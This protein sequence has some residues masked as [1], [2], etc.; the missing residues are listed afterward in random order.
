MIVLIRCNDVV[1][2]TRAAKYI[3]YLDETNQRFYIIGWDRTATVAD[4]KNGTYFKRQAGVNVGGFKAAINRVFWMN[5]VIRALRKLNCDDIV[6]HACD[7][8]SAFP[9]AIYK[10]LF[11]KKAK[12]IFDVFDW[13]SAS[14]NDQGSVITAAFKYMENYTVKRSD[15]IIICEKERMDQIQVPFVSEKLYVL[16]NIPFFDD[17]SFVVKDEAFSFDNDKITFAYVGGFTPTR[18]LDEII[19]LA[20]DGLIN[21][22]IA[23]YGNRDIENRLSMRKCANIKY[24]G[25]VKYAF[26]LNIMY[27]ADIIYAMY[28]KVIPNHIYAAPNK[29]Y[30]ALFLGK[31]LFTTDGTIVE[32]KV[33]EFDTGFT[34]RENLTEIESVIR[35]IKTDEI[36]SKGKTAERVWEE[37]YQSYTLEFMKNEYQMMLTNG[38]N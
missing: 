24:F 23:G 34:S 18:C 4:P 21:L 38:A 16:P 1:S 12:I 7:V 22:L 29:F 8:D 20:E 32:K 36:L 11:N 15:Y 33:K 9:A 13:F 30:E 5:F 37:L 6:I 27:N 19:T 31:A 25:P 28:S 3:K 2:D 10:S 35:S 17:R 26:G 14:M